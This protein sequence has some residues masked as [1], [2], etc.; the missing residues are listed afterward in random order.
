ML[1]PAGVVDYLDCP[2]RV[3]EPGSGLRAE[4]LKVF[5][6]QAGCQQVEL[7]VV[8][9]DHVRRGALFLA[10]FLHFL[11]LALHRLVQWASEQGKFVFGGV[12]VVQ[13]RLDL[14]QPQVVIG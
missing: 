14:I 13:R 2:G 7:E 4:E 9:V 11:G 10:V 8:E 1:Y 12:Q 3:A 6:G 5:Q